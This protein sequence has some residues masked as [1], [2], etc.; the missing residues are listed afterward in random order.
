VTTIEFGGGARPKAQV[1]ML[2][3]RPFVLAIR[4]GQTGSI[5]FLGAVWAPA[6]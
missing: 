2:V 4:D 1:H 3:N 5:L 6:S